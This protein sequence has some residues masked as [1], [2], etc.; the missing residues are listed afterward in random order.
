MQGRFQ[1]VEKTVETLGDRLRKAR[2]AKGL[3][4]EDL[5]D[6]TKIR[7]VYLASMEEGR[8]Q[9]LP[10]NVYIRGFIRSVARAVG[11]A[12]D[13]LVAEYDRIYKQ[14]AIEQGKP[15]ILEGAETQERHKAGKGTPLVAVIGIIIIAS[16][17]F[18]AMLGRPGNMR[19]PDTTS[20]LAV[21]DSL[22]SDSQTES[23]V[24]EDFQGG[25]V[26][27]MTDTLTANHEL[28]AVITERCWVRVICDGERVFEGTLRP[29]EARVWN[30]NNDIR[31]RI[32][33]AGGIDI[34]YNGV[35]KGSPGKSGDV[36]EM[37][38]PVHGN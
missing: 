37:L 22:R 30:A 15:E 12:D 38:L 26:Q 19:D 21:E 23:V 1:E 16:L 13:E 29:G 32:G 18:V 14:S 31:V 17:I 20:V 34:T 7:V 5:H 4:I 9:E 2:E 28:R 33:N 36:I 3:S 25:S 6:I 24:E 35:H 27:D 11:E 8:F 10:G